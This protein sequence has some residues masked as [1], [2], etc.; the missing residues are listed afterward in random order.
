MTALKPGMDGRSVVVR[1]WNTGANSASAVIR[2]ANPV[3][4]AWLC[5]LNEEPSAQL[6]LTR[7][8]VPVEVPPFG[9]ATVSLT[10][11]VGEVNDSTR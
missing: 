11:A 2:P 1:L 9:L 8:G 4:A 10:F 6:P 3:A 7:E 5:N